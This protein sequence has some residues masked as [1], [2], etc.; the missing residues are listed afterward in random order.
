MKNIKKKILYF[1][2]KITP[3]EI[4]FHRKYFDK[5]LSWHHPK[6]SES[7]SGDG[8]GIIQTN[9]IRKEIPKIINKYKIKTIF[10]TACGDFFWMKYLINKKVDYIGGDIVKKI[11]NLNIKK[12]K[13]KNIKFLHIDFTNY[14]IPKSDLI[15]CR[16]ALTHLPLKMGIKS[17]KNFIRSKSKYLLSTTYTNTKK[18]IDI[19]KGNF[20]PINL[21]IKP[22]LLGE[23]IIL[24]NE[25]CSEKNFK[26]KDKSLGLWK[27]N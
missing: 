16:D 20:R 13:K 1:L 12:N 6:K 26:Y 15:I 4:I 22:F 27:I 25:K 18:N 5:K 8:S 14:N 3:T 24:I 7:L 17:K 21:S 23:P 9:I 19:P 2:N 11:I 10:D